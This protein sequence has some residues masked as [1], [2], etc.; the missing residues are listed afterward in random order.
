MRAALSLFLLVVPVA[1]QSQSLWEHNGSIVSLQADGAN[2]QFTYSSPRA[3]L[4]VT[5][6]TLL[7]SGRKSGDTYSGT[8]Y[9]FSNKCGTIG[10]AVQGP[11]SNSDKT[12]TMYGKKPRRDGS[13]RV[14]SSDEVDVLV[15]N[16][17][18]SGRSIETAQEGPSSPTNVCVQPVYIEEER[19]RGM[20]DGNPDTTAE[21]A[22]AIN[23]LNTRYCREITAAPTA[24]VRSVH[25]SNNCFQYSGLFRGERVY[26]H[27]CHE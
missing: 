27:R 3:G 1:A 19:L 2:R 21:I 25:V 23:Y 9:L 17:Q 14:V 11:V 4:P 18:H 6:G 10:Y 5:S 15:F 20:I 16:F 7:F 13:C 8:A 24:D 22:E 26:W 12:V